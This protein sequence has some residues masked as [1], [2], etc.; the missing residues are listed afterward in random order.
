M[1]KS[2]TAVKQYYG[3]GRRK[4]CTA[5]VFIR[6]GSGKMTINTK[7]VEEYFGRDTARMVVRQPVEAVGMVGKFDMYITVKGG[8]DMGQAGAIRHGI[9]RALI[10]YDEEFTGK[11]VAI[12][13]NSEAANDSTDSTETGAMSFRRT[14][15][16]L[17][18]VTRDSRKVER[19]K[20]G[21]RKARKK[22]QYSKR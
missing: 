7:T 16:K 14:L 17:G 21:H 2:S 5:R 15:R 11:L 10:Q 19:K 20:V 4:S 6:A 18:Y 9:T 3:T 1:A 12:E 22:E 13:G 8:G